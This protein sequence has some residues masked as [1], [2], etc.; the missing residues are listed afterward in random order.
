[1]AKRKKKNKKEFSKLIMIAVMSTYFI[2]L[3]FGMIII[4]LVIKFEPSSIGMALSSLFGFIGAP[5]AVAIGFYSY[6]AK[7]E[8]VE[9]I[10]KSYGS[11]EPTDV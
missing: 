7:S 10:R 1:M 9:K 2:G 3:I 6:K 8:N 4:C 11:D 5:V